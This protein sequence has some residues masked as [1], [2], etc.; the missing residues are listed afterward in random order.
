MITDYNSDYPD[1][2]SSWF[3]AVDI[4]QKQIKWQLNLPHSFIQPVLADD[5]LYIITEPNAEPHVLNAVNAITGKI[6]WSQKLK[7]P[8]RA[9]GPIVTNNAVIVP[10]TFDIEIYSRNTHQ[11]MKEI[12]L[13]GA[14]VDIAVANNVLYYT[15]NATDSG[16]PIAKLTAV[17]LN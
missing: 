6:I 8:T 4:E 10:T 9:S 11:L 7:N 5:I 2:G 15:E 3:S 12:M 13:E 1:E 17:K 16:I 14:D